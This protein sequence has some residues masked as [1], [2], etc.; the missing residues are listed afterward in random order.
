MCQCLCC[1]FCRS[2][3]REGCKF[4]SLLGS[5]GKLSARQTLTFP[6]PSLQSHLWN[7]LKSG[8]TWPAQTRVSLREDERPWEWGWVV[9][10]VKCCIL[11]KTTDAIVPVWRL[12]SGF[13]IFDWISHFH[14]HQSTAAYLR[15]LSLLSPSHSFCYHCDGLVGLFLRLGM[16]RMV[17]LCI[18]H[19][20]LRLSSTRDC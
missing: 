16:F 4:H 6:S 5:V 11:I 3:Q 17:L 19:S 1:D 10:N 14:F 9:K 15:I 8:G 2:T 7:L 18:F 20:I 12:F 13:I